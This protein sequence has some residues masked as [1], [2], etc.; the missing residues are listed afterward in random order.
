MND[1]LCGFIEDVAAETSPEAIWRRFTGTM[2]DF[3]FTGLIYGH[4]RVVVGRQLNFQGKIHLF[5][6][7]DQSF[8]DEWLMGGHFGHNPA[9]S[10]ARENSGAASWRAVRD[11]AEANDVEPMNPAA[12]AIWHR[13][14]LRAGYV[15]SFRHF[16]GRS[17]GML[18]L[19]AQGAEHDSLAAIWDRHG[20]LI[21]ALGHV[22]HMRL[23]AMP[24]PPPG[25]APD[26]RAPHLSPRQREVLE[27]IAAGK[28][29][30][31]VA[32]I[33]GL[34][35]VTVEKH[36]RLARI[37]L[38]AETTAQAVTTAIMQDEI[39]SLIGPET[40]EPDSGA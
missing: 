4:Q 12:R 30:A 31:D 22:M 25:R 20:R 37:A 28:T 9:L 32:A 24:T 17:D 26:L 14:D 34:R 40:S 13:H 10:W 21:T 16:A 18:S 2:G 36:L 35:P 38:G 1:L 27:W 29:V 7:H 15:I 39:F 5:A 6:Q 11:W 33:L 8:L 23:S 3:G 19:T